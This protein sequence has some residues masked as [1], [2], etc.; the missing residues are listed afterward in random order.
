MFEFRTLGTIELRD[1]D[2]VLLHE[3]LQHSKRVALLS[4]LAV[5]YPI[6]TQ[7]RGTLIAL[8]WPDLD[9]SHGRGM[10][11]HELYE[12]RRVLGPK[13]FSSD[14]GE[15]LSVNG[16]ALWCD[17]R[18]FESALESGHLVEAMNMARGELLPGLHVN[19][20]EF[21]RWLDVTRDRLVHRTAMAARRL[22]TRAESNGDLAAAIDWCR[23]WTDVKWYDE[24]GWRRLM[25]LLDRVGDRAEALSAYD[26]LSTRLLEELDAEP[27]PETRELAESIRQRRVPISTAGLAPR[28]HE[29]DR[30]ERDTRAG[31]LPSVDQE[32]P[33][34]AV[35]VIRPTEN[36]T[37]D[38]RHDAL[39]KRLT[40]RLA[41]GISE[42]S[43]V[44]VV[45]GE[46]VSWA[47]AVV[48]V[49]LDVGA[50]G[51]EV[52]TRLEDR[53]NGGRLLAAH[54]PVQ[55][56]ESPAEE[57]L[58][59]AVARVMASVAAH[60]DPRVPIAFVGGLPV[61]TPSWESWL[62]FI[63]GSEAFGA[64]RFDEAARHLRRSHEIDP[65]FVKAGIFAAIAIAYCGDPAGA[66]ALA[67]EA[68]RTGAT[69]ASDYERHFGA[70]FLAE[71]HGRRPEAYRACQDT[72]RLTSHPVLMFLA[73]REALRMLRPNEALQILEGAEGGWGW[74]RNWTEI[75][76]VRG[77]AHHILGEHHAEL[78][79]VLRGRSRYP[80]A[81]EPMRAEVRTRAAL[82]EPEAALHVVEQALGLPPRVLSPADI[83]WTAAQELDAHGHLEA[84]AIARQLG[85][86]WL[87]RREPG[88]APEGRLAIRL[89]L[90]SGDLGRAGK[91]LDALAPI[92]DFETLGLAGL[93]AAMTGSTDAATTVIEQL[94][95]IENPYLSGRHLLL[96]A[97]IQAKLG[98][99][100]MAIDALRR[101]RADGLTAVVE[102]HSMPMLRSLVTHPEFEAMLRPRG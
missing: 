88:A 63:Q 49:C 59:Q 1:D 18:A 23:R 9:D 6:R 83:A 64:Y 78:D 43:Y 34:P 98:R 53:A 20:G 58:Y 92:E 85:L 95:A 32:V 12:L 75:F 51:L 73:G 68:L 19:G 15:T 67:T 38:E 69:T 87:A 50:H 55:L 101:A 28:A 13:A 21:D 26:A 31:D 91:R 61:R 97:E 14:G 27:S 25:S 36:L 74:W 17:A 8:L 7:R 76:E 96:E 48:S 89:L 66:E 54:E 57:D 60:Y 72:L 86:N 81:L 16:D 90:E 39:G 11:R 80:E 3:P 82:G 93:L 56:D 22:S 94:R 37:G 42:L 99:P 2:G 24:I 65:D 52:R 29:P 70:W 10:L 40:D 45:I 84:G 62:E 44:E 100:D 71:L 102:L 41:R 30:D 46:E 79:A 47:T 33:V 5:S 77:A 35:I 4:Y